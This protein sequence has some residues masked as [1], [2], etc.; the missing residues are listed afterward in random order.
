MKICGFEA[1]LE[2]PFFLLAG[3][4]VIESEQSAIDT[5]VAKR[6]TRALKIPFVYSLH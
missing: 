4:C 2:H 3:P 6:I 1:G 5:Q